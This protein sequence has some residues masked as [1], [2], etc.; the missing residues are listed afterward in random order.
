MEYSIKNIT[1]DLKKINEML[2]NCSDNDKKNILLQ[3]KYNILSYL[4][5]S[6]DNHKKIVLKNQFSY[7][8]IINS[9]ITNQMSHVPVKKIYYPIK[10]TN[11][12]YISIFEKFMLEDE[13]NL[14]DI[15]DEIQSDNNIFW[16][17]NKSK[18]KSLGCT[19]Y[20][21]SLR[22]NY[23]KINNTGKI[24]D[25]AVLVHELGHAKMN[26]KLQKSF[27]AQHISNFGEAYS[28]FLELEFL[29]YI[30][31]F[32]LLKESFNIK[33]SMLENILATLEYLYENLDKYLKLSETDIYKQNF[34]RRYRIV[35]SN[36]LAFHF[37]NLYLK[38]KDE[39]YE[40]LE[41]FNKKFGKFDD[42]S[43]L[44]N[45]DMNIYDLKNLRILKK[46]CNNLN[47]E[48][49]EVKQKIKQK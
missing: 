7:N 39:C 33:I 35:I 47:K 22:K 14:S 1:D 3:D 24:R 13:F 8:T 29:D 23:I 6:V 49:I 21:E 20:V 45:I 31:N 12:D 38:D 18:V 19:L 46:F 15:Y 41:I 11:L 36:L 48:R 17:K 32:G 26:L 30:K 43:L 44:D 37:Y 5:L 9:I 4:G 16:I 27:N 28:V 42:E 25:Y 10:K 2:K 34:N 40:K